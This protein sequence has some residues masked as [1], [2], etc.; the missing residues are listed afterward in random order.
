MLITC[1]PVWFT[2]LKNTCK[3]F[4]W[5]MACGW[6]INNLKNSWIA[7]AEFLFEG[8]KSKVSF[9]MIKIRP[10]WVDRRTPGDYTFFKHPQKGN[11]DMKDD[12]WRRTDGIWFDFDI[13]YC[14]Y[15]FYCRLCSIWSP[16]S[17]LFFPPSRQFQGAAADAN[18]TND[19]HP[20]ILPISFLGV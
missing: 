18:T 14:E 3:H 5:V 4:W 11:A 6:T 20:Y 9:Y 7:S 15:F 13:V 19:V 1:L 16:Q 2:Q 12:R 8:M 17:E 10:A